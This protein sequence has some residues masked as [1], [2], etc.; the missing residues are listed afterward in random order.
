MTISL[1]IGTLTIIALV[2]LYRSLVDRMDSQEERIAR[3]EE[4]KRKRTNLIT[5]EEIENAMAELAAYELL[6]QNQQQRV[7]SIRGHLS[8][9]HTPKE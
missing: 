9:A 2:M 8:K 1:F 7:D 3:L 4:A 6:I 5:L